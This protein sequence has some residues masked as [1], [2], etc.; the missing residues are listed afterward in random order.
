MLKRKI[1]RRATKG[2]KRLQDIERPYEGKSNKLA[3]T[4]KSFGSVLQTPGLIIFSFQNY[5]SEH[6]C[7]Y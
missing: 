4:S 7:N 2:H 3:W 5:L 1:Y 6:V